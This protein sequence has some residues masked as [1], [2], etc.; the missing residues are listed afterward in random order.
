MCFDSRDFQQSP[1]LAW[2]GIFAVALNQCYLLYTPRS[3]PPHYTNWC[4]HIFA[5][6]HATAAASERPS[7]CCWT[8]TPSVWSRD[9]WICILPGNR[10]DKSLILCASAVLARARRE[11]RF[12]KCVRVLI[13]WWWIYA[14]CV[15]PES[16]FY[17]CTRSGHASCS[18]CKISSFARR[19]HCFRRSDTMRIVS[20]F[21][22]SHVGSDTLTT[23]VDDREVLICSLPP[24]PT[25]HQ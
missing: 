16:C 10:G 11:F 19:F 8:Y 25:I 15:E 24:L 9:Y 20:D 5:W 6:I 23:M 4:V 13:V 7:P 18:L 12:V 22:L 21:R 14:H 17:A 2:L 3:T 1:P